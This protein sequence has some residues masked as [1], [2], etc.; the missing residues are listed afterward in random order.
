MATELR[1]G[2]NKISLEGVLKEKDLEIKTSADGKKYIGGSV[3]IET[4]ENQELKVRVFSF[5]KTKKGTDNKVY[6]GLVTVMDEY[7]SQAEDADNADKVRINGAEFRDNSFSIAGQ[8]KEGVQIS[9]NFINRVKGEFKPK[10]NFEVEIFYTKITPEL[11]NEQEET[12]RMIIGGYIVGYGG[13]ITPIEF[14]STKEAGDYI[15][16]NFE[17]KATGTLA[18]KIVSTVER[19]V[20]KK[21]GFGKARVE[22]TVK[23][24]KEYLVTGGDDQLDEDDPKAYKIEDIKKAI[25][26]RENY[27]ESLRNKEKNTKESSKARK[28]ADDDFPF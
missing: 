18:G 25:K 13:N 11:D 7:T 22:E 5:E 4:G 24:K 3:T 28:E 9:A 20:E 21:E 8:L 14:V 10:A 26:E 23:F 6:K 12:G 19:K 27:L 1:Q 16:S 17:T 2:L 15:E